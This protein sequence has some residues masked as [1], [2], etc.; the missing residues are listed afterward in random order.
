MTQALAYLMPTMVLL[1][2]CPHEATGMV[3]RITVQ[4][5]K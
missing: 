4:E 5:A 3:G 1:T 2:G